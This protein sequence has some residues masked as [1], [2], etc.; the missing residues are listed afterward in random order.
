MRYPCVYWVDHLY[1]ARRSPE[2]DDDLGNNGAIYRFLGGK[3][4]YW[5]EALSLPRSI[6]EGVLAMT[7]WG[8]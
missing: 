4:I 8:D 1:D 7:K 2:H 6:S 5:P 3:C